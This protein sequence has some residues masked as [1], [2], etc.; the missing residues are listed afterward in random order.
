MPTP[1][2]PRKKFHTAHKSGEHQR[3]AAH[4]TMYLRRPR[5]RPGAD[6]R[7]QMTV[8]DMLLRGFAHRIP[9]KKKAEEKLQELSPSCVTT[10][11]ALVAG[12]NPAAPESVK[13]LVVNL[14]IVNSQLRV[15]KCKAYG[16]DV[17]LSKGDYPNKINPFE[18]NVLATC[19]MQATG[20]GQRAL[21]DIFA[22]MN[23]SHMGFLNNATYQRYMKEK[24]NPAIK[25][26]AAKT[27]S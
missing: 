26:A 23:L 7:L 25:S 19:A 2:A 1:E 6:L 11:K 14:N 18:I 13:F 3:S 5:R 27:S 17:K 20:K 21:S 12:T 16:S 4:R 22:T 24:L 9:L 10:R 15:A 8:C